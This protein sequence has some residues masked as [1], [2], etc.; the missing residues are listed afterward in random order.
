MKWEHV[1]CMGE[2]RNAHRIVIV[3]LEGKSPLGRLWRRENVIKMDVHEI[4]RT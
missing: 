3:K 1:S 4:R 2:V